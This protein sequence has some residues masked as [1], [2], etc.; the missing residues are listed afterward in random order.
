MIVSDW[1]LV[2]VGIVR[3]CV[4]EVVTVLTLS[5]CH[6]MCPNKDRS[7]RVLWQVNN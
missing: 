3:R 5:Q 1:N 6:K 2:G 7:D 4:G